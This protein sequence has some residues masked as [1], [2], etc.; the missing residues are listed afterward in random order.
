MFFADHFSTTAAPLNNRYFP[1]WC[2]P[3]NG[4]RHRGK[5]PQHKD[6]PPAKTPQLKVVPHGWLSHQLS[7]RN[8]RVGEKISANYWDFS[9]VDFLNLFFKVFSTATI[10]S[11]T[12]IIFPSTPV[13]L[14]RQNFIAQG[15]C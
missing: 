7:Q 9:S 8:P 12:L 6:S 4:G 2:P 13:I 10:T 1:R 11:K 14:F 15:Q 3:E 5:A